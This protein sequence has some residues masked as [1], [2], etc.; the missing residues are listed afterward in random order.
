MGNG[1]RELT[2]ACPQRIL[3]RAVHENWEVWVEVP[4]VSRGN[5][6]NRLRVDRNWERQLYCKHRIDQRSTEVLVCSRLADCLNWTGTSNRSTGRFIQITKKK[7]QNQNC[8][9]I[10]VITK[11]FFKIELCDSIN[12]DK[13]LKGCLSVIYLFSFSLFDFFKLPWSIVHEERSK[14]DRLSTRLTVE[15]NYMR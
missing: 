14:M 9:F 10:S 3:I 6:R 13:N 11:S 15:L 8:W 2:G 1:R 12:F 4:L 5:Y 7:I